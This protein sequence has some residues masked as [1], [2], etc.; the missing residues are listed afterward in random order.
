VAQQIEKATAADAQ[1]DWDTVA[2]LAERLRDAL[3]ATAA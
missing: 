2:T 3:A 1:P